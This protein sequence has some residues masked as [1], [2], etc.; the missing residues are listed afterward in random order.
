MKAVEL[1]A[2]EIFK[3]RFNKKEAEDLPNYFETKANNVVI[4][5][6]FI[7]WV[8]QPAAMFAFLNYF[9]H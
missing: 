8:T 1:K 3:N 6:M 7:V 2:Y 5:W 4:K 9:V